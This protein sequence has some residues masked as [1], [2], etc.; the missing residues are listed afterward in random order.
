MNTKQ[1]IT[2][3]VTKDVAQEVKLLRLTSVTDVKGNTYTGFPL[4]VHPRNWPYINLPVDPQHGPVVLV[5]F[6]PQE[7]CKCGQ[8]AGR[9]EQNPPD[10]MLADISRCILERSDPEHPHEAVILGCFSSRADVL[11]RRGLLPEQ[12]PEPG[13]EAYGTQQSVSAWLAEIFSPDPTSPS[14][15]AT[16][17]PALQPIPPGPPS[18]NGMV[19]DAFVVEKDI[20]PSGNDRPIRP[21][22]VIVPCIGP[23]PACALIS[24][25]CFSARAKAIAKRLDRDPELPR[26]FRQAELNY[27]RETWAQ[28]QEQTC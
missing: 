1:P 14:D 3:Q 20:D 23:E 22:R 4:T 18:E 10:E 27:S 6:F 28:P 16:R 13:R 24:A 25:A 5:Q 26:W 17:F 8:I 2:I 21:I 12:D 11:A 15:P 9:L 19:D 7:V